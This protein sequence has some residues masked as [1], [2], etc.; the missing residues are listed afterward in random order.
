MKSFLRTNSKEIRARI[1]NEGIECCP[2][3]EFLDAEWLYF[4][5]AKVHGVYPGNDEEEP[6]TEFIFGNK[7]NFKNIFLA[8]HTDC[9]DCGEDVDLFIKMIKA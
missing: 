3:S 1:L 9:I 5:N 2:C 7:D 6:G 8:D 4:S